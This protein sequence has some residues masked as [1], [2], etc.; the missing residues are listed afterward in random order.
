MKHDRLPLPPR[1]LNNLVERFHH[2]YFLYLQTG[3]VTFVTVEMYIISVVAFLLGLVLQV[4][5]GPGW[6]VSMVNC[7]GDDAFF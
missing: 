4:G 2:S 5:N 1:S 3:P 7:P 6:I